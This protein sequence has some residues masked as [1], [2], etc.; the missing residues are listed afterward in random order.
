MGA[1]DYAAVVYDLDG[2]LVDLAVD[3]RAARRDVAAALREADL[4][5]DSTATLWDLFALAEEAGHVEVV[6]TE[7]ARHEGD[8]ATASTA[9]PL[10]DGLPHEIPVGVCSLNAADAC[11]TALK[12]HGIDG[13][14]DVIVGR[15]SHAERKPD[16]G[17]LLAT[18]EAL[19]VEPDRALFV[20]NSKRDAVAAER[21]GVDFEWASEFEPTR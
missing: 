17:P 9:L 6:E 15:D 10:V 18:I 11:E 1:T 3:W 2:T 8:G 21:A 4:E 14:V 13:H 5:V 7:L 20:G 16:P 12:Q 19:G